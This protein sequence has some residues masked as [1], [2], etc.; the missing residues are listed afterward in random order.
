MN[1]APGPEAPPPLEHVPPVEPVVATAP[2]AIEVPSLEHEPQEP[3][4]ERLTAAPAPA[5][6][7]IAPV[8]SEDAPVELQTL[9]VP[10]VQDDVV[11]MGI[12]AILRDNLGEATAAMP[13]EAKTRF[14]AKAQEIGVV[15]ADMVRQYKV[16]VKRV[17]HLLVEWLHTIPGVNKFFLEQEAKLKTDRILQFEQE[18]HAA[19]VPAA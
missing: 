1:V 2:I 18:Q 4:F 6:T 8:S 16:E 11:M 17:L 13:E 12:Q 7:I 10:L 19:P 14:W 5:P 3:S 15:V 9:A